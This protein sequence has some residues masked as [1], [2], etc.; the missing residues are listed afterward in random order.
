MFTYLLTYYS[1]SVMGV[2]AMACEPLV[3]ACGIQFPDQGL[4]TG[5]CIGSADLVP[6]PPEKS[7]SA[8]LETAGEVIL[9]SDI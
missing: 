8:T 1:Y 7:L 9:E 3:A 4:N 5:P 2:L 6:G